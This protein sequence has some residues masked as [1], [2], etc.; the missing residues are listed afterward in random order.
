MKG[1]I[2]SLLWLHF[3]ANLPAQSLDW[4]FSIGAPGVQEF[5]T[6]MALDTA[7]NIYLTGTFGGS[8]DVDPGPDELLLTAMGA[9]DFFIEKYDPTGALIWAKQIGGADDDIS[10]GLTVDFAGNVY[11]CG[12]FSKQ[13][14]FDPGSGVFMMDAFNSPGGFIL[15]L[16]ADG[17]FVWAKAIANPGSNNIVYAITLDA[18]GSVYTTGRYTQTVDFDPGS[19]TAFMTYEGGYDIFVQKLDPNG[20]YLWAKTMGSPSYDEGNDIGIGAD[21]SVYIAGSFEEYVD[22]DPGTG[23]ESAI[24]NGTIEADIFVLKLDVNGD[25]IWV[26]TFGSTYSEVLPKL[27]VDP[28]GNTIV[29]GYGSHAMDV[30]PGAGEFI[31]SPVRVYIQ[32]LDANGTFLWAQTVG[33]TQIGAGPEV[34]T[35]DAGNIYMVGKFTGTVDFDPGVAE[36]MLTTQATTSDVFIEK[37]TPTGNFVWVDRV[38]GLLGDFPTVLCVDDSGQIFLTGMYEN[39]SDV[40][41]S[42]GVYEL[43]SQGSYDIFV[44]KL[45]QNWNFHGTVFRDRNNNQIHDSGEPGLVGAIVKVDD[46][47]QYVT[48]DSSGAYRF[49][50]NI[51]GKTLRLIPDVPYGVVFPEFAIA[52]SS[53]SALDFS[54]YVDTTYR[55]IGVSLV[56]TSPVRSGFNTMYVVYV[57]SYSYLP[58]DSIALTMEVTTHDFPLVNTEPAVAEAFGDSLTWFIPKLQPFEIKAFNITYNSPFSLDFDETISMGAAVDMR[59]DTFLAN[60]RASLRVPVVGSYDPNDKRVFPAQVPPSA[61]DST[62]LNYVIRFQ[63]TGNYP[64]DFVVIRDTLPSRLDITTFE[65]LGASHPFTWRLYNEAILEVRFDPIFLPDSISNEPESHGFVA[66]KVKP[67]SN[68]MLGDTI[69]NRAGIYFDYNPPVITNTSVMKVALIT[70]VTAPESAGLLEINLFPNPVTPAIPVNLTLHGVEATQEWQIV[71][72]DVFGRVVFQ[73]STQEIQPSVDLSELA[74][75]TYF[76]QVSNRYVTGTKKLMVVTK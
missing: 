75:G 60:N 15:K 58:L 30:D 32:K 8:I 6:G 70:R 9:R 31:L 38:G 4:A 20:N 28:Q 73:Q 29:T 49:Y 33:S 23:I 2:I 71:L 5:S 21:G 35:D 52:D 57:K 13:V 64:A 67:A 68:M 22:F 34:T 12:S 61:L 27:A 54:V 44:L 17:N 42:P 19:G 63:N 51:S 66:F 36:A 62:W 50:S 1:F 65:M 45:G 76:I 41:P 16:S 40:D 26:K 59:D 74:A 39:Q 3:W 46:A 43:Q 10:R 24:S 11:I 14:D 72:Y 25:F 48:T 69:P 53:Q 56:Q 47:Q 37:F 55:D 7:G 18:S